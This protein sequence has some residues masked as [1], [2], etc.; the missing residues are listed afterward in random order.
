MHMHNKVAV[1]IMDELATDITQTTLGLAH[2]LIITNLGPL[3]MQ[4]H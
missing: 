3:V 4:L 2:V 1:N